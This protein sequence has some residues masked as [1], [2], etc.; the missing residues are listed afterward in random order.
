MA[1][2]HVNTAKTPIFRLN[3]GA[4]EVLLFLHKA[5]E[6][7]PKQKSGRNRKEIIRWGFLGGHEEPG[8]TLLQT[9]QREAEQETKAVDGTYL[10]LEEEMFSEE[11][12]VHGPILESQRDDDSET[13]QNHFVPAVVPT[14]TIIPE[15]DPTNDEIIRG[16][17]YPLDGE[18]KLP[19]PDDAI[20]FTQTQAYALEEILELFA[21]KWKAAFTAFETV[22][23][24][25][26]HYEARK[27]QTR[28]HR[29]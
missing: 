15:I 4:L 3:N 10:H 6:N 8:E 25:L 7:T 1:E 13:Y 29:Y 5:R 11:Y 9:I 16:E 23:T 19:M 12:A 27:S 26:D 22:K 18:H 14:D 28:K 2:K 24:Q 21:K 17:W 20:P